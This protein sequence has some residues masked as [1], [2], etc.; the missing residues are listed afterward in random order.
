MT[1]KVL[2]I[3]G[4]AIKGGNVE[5]LLRE[6]LKAAGEMGDVETEMIT[7]RDKK[8]GHCIHCNWC[9][10]K[11]EEGKFCKQDDDMTDIYAKLVAADALLLAS[12]VYVGRLS[13]QLATLLDR[14]FVFA[15][16][17]YYRQKLEGKVGGALAVGYLRDSGE[18]P[19]L[20]SI[21]WSF[22]H[23][24]MIPVGAGIHGVMGAS[25]VSSLEGTGGFDSKDR[26]HVLKDAYG[27]RS[28]RTLARRVVLVT[29]MIKA[30][31]NAL[32]QNLQEELE[33]VLSGRTYYDEKGARRRSTSGS[34]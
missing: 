24:G 31:E 4:S 2:G 7:L 12:P 8:I 34:S 6:A 27:L 33:H 25:A 32:N 20:A 17:N 3:C 13:G 21:H 9:Y 30:G 1:I 14:F 22:F 15:R 23:M 16:G 5:L 28:A 29:S 10:R 19:T 18:E 11:E 26:H